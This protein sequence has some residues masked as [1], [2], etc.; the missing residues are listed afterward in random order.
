[1]A[2]I[3]VETRGKMVISLDS[4][5]QKAADL[6]AKHRGEDLWN[7]GYHEDFPD[8][9]YA[10]HA[11]DVFLYQVP[12]EIRNRYWGHGI[13]RGSLEDQLTALMVI[14]EKGLIIGWQGRIAHGKNE[15]YMLAY[16]HGSSLILSKIDKSL[17]KQG[18][19][20]DRFSFG[21]D[22]V[23]MED[24][25]MYHEVELKGEQKT[26]TEADVNVIILNSELYSFYE[27]LKAMYPKVKFIKANQI[28]DFFM[29]MENEPDPMSLQ[30]LM[31]SFATS[32]RDLL[33]R[34][35]FGK[36]KKKGSIDDFF[37]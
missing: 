1:M 20:P 24:E 15:T 36:N 3:D 28:P 13:T 5:R 31:A 11:I 9:D 17:L 21:K 10:N 25:S 7:D 33:S 18:K 30:K 35:K 19:H 12:A 32:V 27:E 22:G 6:F 8:R 26:A 34:L 16:T 29:S 37:E 2:Q 23:V 4:I 14:A